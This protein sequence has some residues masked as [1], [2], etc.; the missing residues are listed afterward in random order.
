MLEISRTTLSL[1]AEELIELERIV[2]DE[3]IKA[4]M[5]FLKR[6]IYRKLV[7]SQEGRMK[8]PLGGCAGPQGPGAVKD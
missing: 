8:S 1:E 6:S 3:D 4:A 7:A 2:I 5:S